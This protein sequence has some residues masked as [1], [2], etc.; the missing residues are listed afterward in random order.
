MYLWEI[1][2]IDSEKAYFEPSYHVLRNL[3]NMEFQRN[4]NEYA[5]L[6]VGRSPYEEIR[7][8]VNEKS[9]SHEIGGIIINPLN[10][11]FT[12]I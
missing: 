3:I 7:D 11:S 1:A 12:L 9:Y 10:A 4:I 2:L 6:L 8:Y 5:S